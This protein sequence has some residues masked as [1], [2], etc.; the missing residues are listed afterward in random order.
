MRYWLLLILWCVATPAWADVFNYAMVKSKSSL[1][2]FA[3]HKDG[4]IQG[5][6]TDFDVQIR[7]GRDALEKSSIVAEVNTASV[8]SDDAK[9]VEALK[10]PQWLS[11]QLFPKA[12][13]VSTSISVMPN[14]ENYIAKGNLT[15]RDKTIPAV[16]NFQLKPRGDTEIAE[17]FMTI[18]RNEIG[19][20]EGEWKSDDALKF[21]V[22][23]EFRL[24]ANKQS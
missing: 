21:E 9:L 19:L 6:F 15:I 4:P 3:I 5:K 10:M 20:A 2:F 22:R 18:R 23:I 14:T 16:V 7:F 13:F 17:G 1:K 24:I 11:T 12:R 8:T